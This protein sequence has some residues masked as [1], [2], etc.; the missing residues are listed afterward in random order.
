MRYRVALVIILFLLFISQSPVAAVGIGAQPVLYDTGGSPPLGSVKFNCTLTE[1]MEY[2]LTEDSLDPINGYDTGYLFYESIG[3]WLVDFNK[4]PNASEGD[5]FN[6]YV[7]V[8][9]ESK[10]GAYSGIVPGEDVVFPGQTV[11]SAADYPG[12]PTGLSAEVLGSTSKYVR[13]TFDQLPGITYYLYRSSNPSAGDNQLSDC[14]YHLINGNASSPAYD[15]DVIEGLY[16]WYLLLPQDEAS[17]FGPHTDELRVFI[18]D[19]TSTPTATFTATATPT[20]TPGITATPTATATMVQWYAQDEYGYSGQ[21]SNYSWIEISGS[22]TPIS[23]GDDSSHHLYFDFNFIFYGQRYTSVNISSN[24][25]LSF[26]SAAA[27]P[28]NSSIPDEQT[29]NGLLALFWDDLDP[30][31]GGNVYYKV[32][33]TYPSRYAIIQYDD[34]PIYGTTSRITAQ[35]IFQEGSDQVLFQYKD[36]D[37][38]SLGSGGSATVGI[39]S[40]DGALGIQYSHNT[41]WVLAGS[42]AFL[43]L[44]P[45]TLPYTT[46]HQP[47]RGASGVFAN[48]CIYARVMAAGGGVNPDSI[49]MEVEGEV[50]DVR[51]VPISG[52]YSVLYRPSSNW[53]ASQ[54]VDVRID[55]SDNGSPPQWMEPDIYQF[56]IRANGAVDPFNPI[57]RNITP[58][59]GDSGVAPFIPIEF[60]MVDYRTGIDPEALI[61]QVQG[62]EHAADCN[63][64]IIDYGWHVAYYHPPFAFGEQVSVY[65]RAYD[66]TWAQNNFDQESFSFTVLSAPSMTPSPTA[67]PTITPTPTV[68]PTTEGNPFPFLDG[69]EDGNL[70][71]YVINADASGDLPL[72]RADDSPVGTEAYSGNWVAYLGDA[73]SGGYAVSTLDLHL[74]LDGQTEA[75]LSYWWYT[76]SFEGGHWIYLDIF[77][78]EWH[79]A[80]RATSGTNGWERQSVELGQFDMIEDF[81]IRFRAIMDYPENADA[82]YLD[83]IVVFHAGEPTFTPTSTPTATEPGDPTLTPTLTKTPTSTPTSTSTPTGMATFTPTNTP[84]ATY[85]SLPTPQELHSWSQ[86]RAHAS[87]RGKSSNIAKPSA[88]INWSNEVGE[89]QNSSPAVNSEGAIAIG[90]L[91]GLY[92]LTAQGTLAWSYPV[93]GGVYL[94]PAWISDQSLV[95]GDGDNRLLSLSSQGAFWWEMDLGS[96]LSGAVTASNDHHCYIALANGAIYSI[97]ADGSIFWSYDVG[98]QPNCSPAVYNDGQAIEDS[99][100]AVTVNRG[101]IYLLNG[102]GEL[103]WSYSLPGEELHSPLFDSMGNAYACTAAGRI[104]SLN[105]SG[106]IRWSVDTGSP[107]SEPIACGTADNILSIGIDGRITCFNNLGQLI[108]QRQGFATP[109]TPLSLDRLGNMY[110]GS[111]GGIVYALDNDGFGR[112]SEALQSG[113]EIAGSLAVA[114]DGSLLVGQQGSNVLYCLG[115]GDSEPPFVT[116][117][118]PERYAEDVPANTSIEFDILDDS[119]VDGSSISM[120]VNGE[121]VTPNLS[122]IG[123]GFHVSYQPPQ[124]FRYGQRVTI[125]VDASDINH[126]PMLREVYYFTIEYSLTPTATGSIFPTATP[127]RTPHPSSPYTDGHDPAKNQRSVPP[128]CN[129]SLRIKDDDSGVNRHSIRMTVEDVDVTYNLRG[130]DFNLHL[131][132]YPEYPFQFDQVV[133]VTIDCSDWNGISMPTDIYSF[134]I[135]SR[136]VT[137]TPT[138]T[139]T[140]TPTEAISATPTLTY[141]PSDPRFS[142][143]YILMAGYMNTSITWEAGGIFDMIAWVS[144]PQGQGVSKVNILY[145]GA[146]TGVTLPRWEGNPDVFWLSGVEVAPG[147]QPKEY[148]LE[149]QAISIPGAVSLTWPYLTINHASG[150]SY[151]ADL[152]PALPQS[153]EVFYH[154][155]IMSEGKDSMDRPVIYAAGYYNTFLVEDEAGAFIILA[156]V[157]DRQGI[158]D[159]QRLEV[160]YNGEP[161]GILLHDDGLHGDFESQDG[162]FGFRIYFPQ[163]ELEGMSGIYLLELVATDNAGN[164]SLPWPYLTIE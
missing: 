90:C 17:V 122:A 95:F 55:A 46:A 161:T 72:V 128:D 48:T 152:E 159:I 156:V 121:L 25:F 18:G 116:N 131:T 142:K 162:V 65:I 147:L 38:T 143:P 119:Q 20:D 8:A 67:T 75:S 129:I 57:I 124:P 58:A 76:H 109:T 92:C 93:P 52:G 66:L 110:F 102:R 45:E 87:K 3:Y 15:H 164:T 54:V 96:P 63:Y 21:T 106:G 24:G 113:M 26:T 160:L 104:I 138:A 4:F 97:Q 154:R 137:P 5:P 84:T 130:S 155:L 30:S 94:T 28:D 36:V 83:E 103:L 41:P 79:S 64:S 120:T 86:F 60:D 107:I 7:Y 27:S 61:F 88:G 14:I 23:L 101:K 136:T 13:I 99:R 33:G 32:E 77:D 70:D 127:T 135:I 39:E 115:S 6:V 132:H 145:G 42:Y 98:D 2:L 50:K 1:G 47:P 44:P 163:G 81:I 9:A 141:T 114:E 126:N 82:A 16:Y 139:P 78:G 148:L 108:F 89:I 149:L 118:H 134:F 19:P 69:F 11:V 105:T 43:F 56:T 37:N 133:N 158:E 12:E 74:D 85:T 157:G 117:H 146:P 51:V 91:D 53:S 144:D 150:G 59:P 35:V 31:S 151:S 29:P 100:I 73:T 34:I 125:T 10:A 68:T 22:G 112:W 40:V 80:V 49:S 111:S 153:W 71:E 123:G 62:N 140:V